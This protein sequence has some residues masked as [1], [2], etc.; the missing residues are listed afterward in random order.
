M[1]LSVQLRA[2]RAA[3]A[4]RRGLILG[5]LALTVAMLYLASL[6]FG[7]TF[8]TPAEVWRVVL[9]EQVPGASY[10]VGELRLPRASLGLLAG[11]AFGA[12]GVIF[13]TLLRNQLASPDII[14]IS[15]GASA[16]G[17]IGIVTLG[18]SQTQVSLLSLVASLGTAALI[19][20]LSYQQGFAGTR[21]ILT[22]IGVSAVLGSVVTY[23]LSRAAAWD[24]PAA[25]R[26]MTGSLNGA[27][28]ERSLPLVLVCLLVF[29]LLA[30]STHSFAVLRFGDETAV[31]LGVPVTT[32]RLLA[33][34]AAVALI[35]VATSAC[36]PIAFVAFMSGPIAI[37]LVGGAAKLLLPSALVGAALVLASDLLGQY[38]F[39]SRYPVGV[40]TGALGAP[41]LVYLLIRANRQ[42][43]N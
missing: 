40:I 2:Q 8:Y 34:L 23:V 16:A 3:R 32:V 27:T 7:E 4:R 1:S 25:T 19:Y 36:G 13:Q 10:T 17:V 38:A 15:A 28:W 42:R 14:G 41:F 22:G 24:L 43:R 20:M 11:L 26:W 37:R 31:G 12:S 18:L 21:L 35:A 9:G 29:P 33:I 6:L 30:W 39:G 5:L